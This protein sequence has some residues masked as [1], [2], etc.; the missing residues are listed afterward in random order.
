MDNLYDNTPGV[1]ELKANDLQKLDNAAGELKVIATRPEFNNKV[2]FLAFYAPWCG[3]CVRMV[4]DVKLL[5]KA[6]KNEGFLVGA[7]NCEAN[8]QEL[9][10]RQIN[11]TSFPTLFFVKDN[12]PVKYEGA[13]DLK[14]LLD[15]LCS[16]LGKCV[17]RN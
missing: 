8:K 11:I 14:S 9:D 5:A 4:D 2:Y 16:S 12:V 7:V 1:V 3:H 6:L 17:R 10:K 13:R 15:H